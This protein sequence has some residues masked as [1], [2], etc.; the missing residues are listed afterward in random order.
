MNTRRPA[1]TSAPIDPA[2]VA[3]LKPRAAAWFESLRD[4]ICAAF[5]Q[6]EDEASGPF[7]PEADAAPGR[8]VRTPWQR[9]N[10]DGV[11]GGGGVMSIMKGRVFEKVG[12]HVSTVRVPSRRT[13]WGYCAPS[14]SAALSRWRAGRPAGTP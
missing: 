13:R 3:A 9:S 1:E 14:V 6:V 10:H 7:T 8:F 2:I 11:P 5:E 4:R 12:V